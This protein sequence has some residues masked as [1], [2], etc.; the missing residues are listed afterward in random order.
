MV[1]NSTHCL[2]RA[3]WFHLMS[4]W[5]GS[6]PGYHDTFS[7]DDSSGSFWLYQCPRLFLSFYNLNRGCPSVDICV[8][9]LLVL[10]CMFWGS[11]TQRCS[12][13][14]T[15]S[16]PGWHSVNM[17]DLDH[18]T[19]VGFEVA[20]VKV[21][22]CEVTFLSPSSPHPS[23]ALFHTMLYGRKRVQPILN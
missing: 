19:K 8:F 7:C 22:Y 2:F 20:F 13:I 4:L 21:L 1:I 6:H 12:A 16:Y 9:P 18:L 10:G 17:G 3:P 11:R 14:F 15:M 23:P 5:S